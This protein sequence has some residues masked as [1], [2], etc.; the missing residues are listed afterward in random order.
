MALEHLNTAAK[1]LNQKE[2]HKTR[3]RH[4]PTSPALTEVLKPAVPVLA[5]VGKGLRGD[6]RRCLSFCSTAGG[7]CVTVLSGLPHGARIPVA[8]QAIETAGDTVVRYLFL[9]SLNESRVRNSNRYCRLVT[10]LPNPA[11][12][13]GFGIFVRF[14]PFVGALASAVLPTLAASP[15]FRAGSKSLE[16]LG[17]LL[18]SINSQRILSE[19][20]LIGL[21][22]GVSPVA[23]LFSAMN[24]T[25]LWESQG[26][27]WPHL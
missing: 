1:C 12:W 8:A 5:A 3:S 27:R 11:F 10:R 14:I 17:P 7:T 4:F 23:L 9:F 13:G 21:G 2:K 20:F 6:P 16:V 19:P 25:W 22:I 18:L 26:C 24:W 15:Y